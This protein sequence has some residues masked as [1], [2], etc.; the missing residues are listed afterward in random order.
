MVN[1]NRLAFIYD[2]LKWLVF[3]GTIDKATRFYLGTIPENA[4]VLILGGGTGALLQQLKPS[5]LIDYVELSTQM[6]KKA[7]NRPFQAKV[8]FYQ[9]D[10]LRF[11]T[12]AS[13]DYV[14]TPFILDCFS[15]EQLYSILQ[16]YQAFIK[17]RGY[18][19][20]TD[21]YAQNKGQN[22]LVKCMYFFFRLT[23]GLKQ[24]QLPDFNKAFQ[25]NAFIEKNNVRFKHGLIQSRLYQKIE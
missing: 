7:K 21:F 1:F 25:K 3:Q 19:I 14:I 5:H 13:Y 18:W 11:S 23:A 12:E 17:P 24:A 15:E 2:S 9:E 10:L 8:N 6:I 20:Q 22:F 4:R 16:K